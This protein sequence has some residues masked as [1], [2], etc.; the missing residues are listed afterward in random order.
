MTTY[1]DNLKRRMAG[2]RQ[3]LPLFENLRHP[4][5]RCLN[6]AASSLSQAQAAHAHILKTG[7]SAD[8]HLSTKLLSLYANHHPSPAHAVLLLHSLPD[9][10]LFSFSTLVHAFTK[11][12]RFPLALR[13]FAQMVS[14]GI[15]P[16]TYVLPSV[17]KACG[18]LSSVTAGKQVHCV[19]SV[20]GF[21]SD[22]L[23]LSSLFHMYVQLDRITEARQVFDRMP[24]PDVVTCS[25][26]LSQYARRGLVQDTEE[27]LCRIR[28]IGLELNL[29]SW[30]GMISGFNHSGRHLEAV[31]LFRNMHLEGFRPDEAGLSS[32]LPPVGALEMLEIGVQIHGHAIKLGFAQDKCVVSA[33]VDMYGKCACAVEM[34]RVFEDMDEKDVGVCNALITGLS[35]N[36]LVFAARDEV[37]IGR[38]ILG[39]CILSLVRCL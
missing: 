23:V 12:R 32:V 24:H 20:S 5:L 14:L 38:V 22:S 13:I 18:G 37:P 17:L 16:D 30:N 9:P 33:L 35:R 31:V 1:D 29:V 28:D 15:G 34:S 27:L 10:T 3:L 19:A 36:G 6:P 2:N 4:I 7:I 11:L 8:T 39:I 25:A 26:L 21:D